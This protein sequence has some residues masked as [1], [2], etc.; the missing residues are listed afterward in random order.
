MRSQ[1]SFAACACAAERAGTATRI[2]VEIVRKHSDQVAFAV[3]PT[4]WVVER[5]PAWID[6]SRRLA[7]D[8]EASIASA[9]GY[10]YAASVILLT[11][12]LARSSRVSSRTLRE[13][14]S[15]PQ[16]R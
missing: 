8:F 16:G 13:T 6:R 5:C 11:R 15:P 14:H 12:R 7:K 4:R 3:H 1:C 9:E 10:L 2:V